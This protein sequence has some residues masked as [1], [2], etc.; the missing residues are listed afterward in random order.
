M[1]QIINVPDDVANL[2]EQTGTKPK[3]WFQDENSVNYLF[4]E[5]RSRTGDDWSEKVASELCGLLELP[6]VA[7]ELAV[8]R[9]KRGVVCQN[10]V[11][12][13]GRLVHG[14]ELLARI[15]T[16]YQPKQF[17]HVR[18]HTLRRVLAI[19]RD[20]RIKVPIGCNLFPHVD[21]A[22]DVFVGYLM[23]DAWIANQD[24]HHENWALVDSEGPVRH[25]APTYDHASSLGSNEIDKNRKDR[26]T[27]RDAGRSMEHYVERATSAFFLSPSSLRPMSTL[28]AFR[29]AG[30]IR[31]KAATTW[32]ES[33]ERLSLQG[34][35]IIFDQIPRDR[36]SEV[37][38][39]FALKMLEL[40]RRR[41]LGLYEV[42]R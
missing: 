37:A 2:P 6:H 24:R 8:W 39:D 29:E 35:K 26:L 21:S 16:G 40:N 41:L 22:I 3:F 18:Q 20:E 23:F 32:L 1:Y 30:K 17:F 12:E 15:V 14:N 28:D 31:Q 27:T 9:G 33:L 34:A 7:Y 19:I 13:G 36:I 42:L 11:P 25:L 4:K 5:G 38:I 10:F